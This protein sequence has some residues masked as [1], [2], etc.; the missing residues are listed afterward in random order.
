MEP[1]MGEHFLLKIETA[2]SLYHPHAKDMPII[3]YH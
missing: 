1:F 2:V 3:D